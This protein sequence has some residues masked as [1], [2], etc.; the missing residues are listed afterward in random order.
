[1]HLNRET[2][3]TSENGEQIS[4][5]TLANDNGIRIEIISYGGI[6]THI[7]T[8]DRNGNTA[9][10]LL[11]LEN[12]E[13]YCAR[14]YQNVSPYFG[15]IIGRYCNRIKNG[16][17]KIGSYEYLLSNN[18]GK[19]HLHGG[20]QGFDKI[21]WDAETSV[22][23]DAVSVILTHSSPD[24]D[25]GFPGNLRAMVIYSL[26]RDNEFSIEYK[27]VTDTPTPVNLTS[28][29]YFNLSG[30]SRKDIADHVLMIEADH[31]TETEEDLIPTGRI[32]PV[33]ETIFDFRAP[34]DLQKI[35][36]KKPGV[37]DL[38]FVL[39]STT[40]N[41]K[42]AVSLY[43]KVSGRKLEII[44]GQPG[45]QVFALRLDNFPMKIKGDPG[46]SQVYGLALEPQH[47]PDS[48]NHP[49]FPDTILNPDK[50]YRWKSVYRFSV[51]D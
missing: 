46:L 7:Y 22:E 30:D 25:Q 10:I 26:N 44:T 42:P 50:I 18:D 12:P 21:I 6:I 32:L 14:Q 9:D 28:H 17:F 4:G 16:R 43:D 29:T 24:G 31:Y 2:I 33:K 1:M 20:F 8:P 45:L 40:G 19:H 49:H 47:F 51:K 35:L 48:P 23:K 11:G 36:K 39:N 38:N 15:A 41:N 13:E 27:C 34:S 5:F 3:S 37:F